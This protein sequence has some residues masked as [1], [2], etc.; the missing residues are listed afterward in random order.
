[1]NLDKLNPWNWFKH[2]QQPQN[3]SVHHQAPAINQTTNQSNNYHPVVK[4]HQ[5]FDRLFDDLFNAFS[6]PAMTQ[7]TFNQMDDLFRPNIDI[8]G[9]NTHYDIHLDVPGLD[10]KNLTIDVQDDALIIKG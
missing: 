7:K 8:S 6:L 3:V 2:E 1:M 9:T 4:L 10:A 5:E